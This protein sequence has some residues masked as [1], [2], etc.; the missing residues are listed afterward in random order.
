MPPSAIATHRCPACASATEPGQVSCR[1]CGHRTAPEDATWDLG[2]ALAGPAALKASGL[3]HRRY[4]VRREIGRGGMGIVYLAFDREL[5]EL[6]AL[7]VLAPSARAHPDLVTRFKHEVKVARRLTHPAIARLHDLV[8][9]NGQLCLSMEH[10]EG[11]SLRDLITHQAPF[12]P[13]RM[14]QWLRHIA[15]AVDLA[16]SLGIVHRDLKPGNVIIDRDDFPHILDFGIAKSQWLEEQG[17]NLVGTPAY[18]APEQGRELATVDGRADLYSLGVMLYELTTGK[19]PFDHHNPL[20]LMDMHRSRMPR[21]PRRL[22]PDLPVDVEQVILRLLE[23]DPARRF[24]CA[25]AALAAI[26]PEAAAAR[27]E[28]EAAP[29]AEPT[30]SPCRRVLVADDDP[31]VRQ[32]LGDQIRARGLEVLEAYD[33]AQAVEIAFREPPGLVLLDVLMPVLD[34]L[35]VLRLLKHD[36]RTRDVPVV[37]MSVYNEPGQIAFCK[38]QGAASFLDKPIS[39]EV[40]ALLVER[41][42]R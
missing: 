15:P 13:D 38:D 16:H 23:K 42:F 19:R 18:M 10:I 34:G 31:V 26:A 36:P 40:L 5:D 20:I 22:R 12:P 28:A 11:P 32:L 6:I 41:Y 7:K 17:D 1:S 9:I 37:V 29:P 4:E 39:N 3:F 33:G 2:P 27:P 35:E 21:P 14:I 25:A 24:P 8:E 30:P